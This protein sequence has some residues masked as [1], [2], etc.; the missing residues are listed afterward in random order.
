[1]I[2]EAGW[3]LPDEQIILSKLRLMDR[4]LRREHATR[5]QD[6]ERKAAGE[7]QDAP[8]AVLRQ[9]IR[10]VEQGDD[11]GFCAEVKRLWTEAGMP[12]KWP[13]NMDDEGDY[14]DDSEDMRTAAEDIS[15]HRLSAAIHERSRTHTDVPYNELWDGSTWRTANGSRRQVGLMTTARLDGLVM[16]DARSVQSSGSPRECPC[17]GRGYDNLRHALLS[18]EHPSMKERQAT[19]TTKLKAILDPRQQQELQTL[20]PH[21]KKMFLLGKQLKNKLRQESQK[22]LDLAMKQFLVSTDDYRVDELGL[23]PMCGRTYTRPPEESLQQA[24][25]WDRMWRAEQWTNNKKA[26][27]GGDDDHNEPDTFSH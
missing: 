7:S 16:Y 6:T 23:N 22:E 5:L 18:C 1:M 20:E 26:P 25:Q 10:D 17:C 13:P 8:S 15:W 27:E 14:E 9:R 19:L 11:R 2:A 4:L 12:H 24:A 3:V 21:E